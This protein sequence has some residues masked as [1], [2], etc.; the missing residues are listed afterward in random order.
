MNNTYKP[1]NLN[2]YIGQKTVVENLKIYIASAL[3]NNKV[4]DHIIFYG[5]PG[6]GKTTLA[7]IVANESPLAQGNTRLASFKFPGILI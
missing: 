6:L 3:K 5:L 7:S 1:Y 4:I 2:D